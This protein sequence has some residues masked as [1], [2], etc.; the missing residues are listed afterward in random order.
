M[1]S[2]LCTT[3]RR[4]GNLRKGAEA[5]GKMED[6]G[7]G[8]STHLRISEPLAVMKI[9]EVMLEWQNKEKVAGHRSSLG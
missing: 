7:R 4:E 3:L 6:V 2:A 8:I 5:G 1:P 9:S